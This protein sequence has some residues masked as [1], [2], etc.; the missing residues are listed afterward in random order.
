MTFQSWFDDRSLLFGPTP[1]ARHHWRRCLVPTSL[2]VVVLFADTVWADDGQPE[3]TQLS[4]QQVL[5]HARN[6]DS[7]KRS[8]LNI[9]FAQAEL[10]RLA[11]QESWSTAVTLSGSG[12]LVMPDQ[13]VELKGDVAL[14]KQLSTGGRVQLSALRSHTTATMNTTPVEDTTAS[15]RVTQPLL[16]GAG[17]NGVAERRFAEFQLEERKSAKRNNLNNLLRDVVSA[18]WEV[19][20]AL[21][22]FSLRRSSLIMTREQLRI[23][24]TRHKAGRVSALEVDAVKQDIAKQ[25]AQLL[26]ARAQFTSRC[27]ILRQL[28]GMPSSTG[29]VE[30]RPSTPLKVSDVPYNRESVAVT[31]LRDNPQ[32][33]LR[34]AELDTAS[35]RAEFAENDRRPR[36]DIEASASS[37]ISPNT[38]NQMWGLQLVFE[39]ELGGR[40]RRGLSKRAK[41]LR[42]IARIEMEI[43]RQELLAAVARASA[44]YNTGR[45]RVAAAQRAAERAQRVVNSERARFRAGRSTAFDVLLRIQSLRDAE[46]IRSRA[47]VDHLIA[48][49]ELEALTGKLV[50][51]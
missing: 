27:A 9:D 16:R 41:T 15:M 14:Q 32:L 37:R 18:Y 28:A 30:F 51:R 35:K 45:Q 44:S 5:S 22:E 36:L 50:E 46:L 6:S 19:A 38:E 49:A 34:Q 4:L 47:V 12:S 7:A 21:E 10:D 11:G 25:Q 40:R 39:Q 43:T 2:I 20:F 13:P 8:L 26:Q 42:R 33:A 29:R 48:S 31:A 3:L 24:E 1:T 17:W 23:V